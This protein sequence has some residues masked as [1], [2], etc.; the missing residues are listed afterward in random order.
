[1]R[2]LYRKA[3][4]KINLTHTSDKEP[5]QIFVPSQNEFDEWLPEESFSSSG[6][7]IGNK[8]HRLLENQKSF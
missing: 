7:G 3:R 8:L 1:M 6:S 4:D 5:E 2:N